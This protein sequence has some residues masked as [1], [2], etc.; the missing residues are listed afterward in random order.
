[1]KDNK[2]VND[3]DVEDFAKNSKFKTNSSNTYRYFNINENKQIRITKN[4]KSGIGKGYHV[5]LHEKAE[6]AG[7]KTENILNIFEISLHDAKRRAAI[8]YFNEIVI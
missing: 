5:T 4:N 2:N 1:M 6:D 3:F 8:I 7:Y